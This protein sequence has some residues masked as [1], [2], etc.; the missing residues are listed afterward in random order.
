V[1]GP[2]GTNTEGIF[3]AVSGYYPVL[4]DGVVLGEALRTLYPDPTIHEIH[5]RTVFGLSQDR[6]YFYMM[7]IDGRQG[8]AQNVNPPYS[9]GANDA[10]MGL[11]LLQ[12]G[13]WD[14]INMDGGGST[15]MYMADCAG[16]PMALGHSSYVEAWHRERITGSHIGVYAPPIPTFIDSVSAAPGS[17]NATI[18]WNTI[19]PASSQVEY[20]T[21]TN[22]GS[23]SPVNSTPT[24]NHSVILNNLKPLTRYYFRAI[25]IVSNNVFSYTCPGTPFQTTN[26]AGGIIFPITN[27]W[28]YSTANLDGVSW[29]IPDYDDSTWTNGRAAFWANNGSGPTNNIPNL[30]TRMPIGSM[31]PFPTY[32]FRTKFNLPAGLIDPTIVFSNYLDDGAVFYLNGVEIYRTNMPAGVI[33]NGTYTGILTCGAVGNAT[34]PILFTFTGNAL[35]NFLAGTN[36]LAVEVHNAGF[37]SSDIVFESALF[38]TLPPPPPSPPFFTNIF[39]LTGETNAV[40]TW[41]TLSNSTSQIMFGPTP[42]LGRETDFEESPVGSHAA[43]LTDLQPKTTYYFRII[44]LVGTNEESFEGTFTSASFYEPLVTA[45]NVWRYTTNKVSG[46]NWRGLNYDDAYWQGEG[47]ALLYNEENGAVQP[48]NT[49]VPLANN[50][51]PA[52]TYYF[53][54]H[55][56]IESETDGF[57]LLFTNYI[58][59]G[60][61]FYLNGVEIQRVRM[62]PGTNAQAYE[63]LTSGC[64]LNNCDSTADV[65]D[66]F[67]LSGP[68]LSLLNIDGDNVL[69]AEVHQTSANS[70]DIVFGSVMGLIRGAANETFMRVTRNEDMVCIDWGGAY[71]TLQ[72]SSAPRGPWTDVPGPVKFSPYCV[73]NLSSSVFYRLKN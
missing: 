30:I 31:Y 18:T 50:G 29:K 10:E 73:T 56:T 14:G 16:K 46:I 33:T 66:V 43:V 72:Q 34:C 65:P 27:M 11:W 60:A 19:A 17:V 69:T 55:F 47:P 63:S 35:T 49:L 26:F 70:S 6:R 37:S 61:I 38:Y 59:D 67:R 39:V 20:G 62:A 2:P 23:L 15:A 41:D 13:A 28:R 9:D 58:D 4:T 36:T 40:I 51:F 53:R 12:F 3:T 5:P 21:T 1:H 52:P 48:R 32:Y 45:A 57:A 68:M 64:P 25:S 42:A 71:A 44:S 22:F 24:T 54:T 7:I 8:A